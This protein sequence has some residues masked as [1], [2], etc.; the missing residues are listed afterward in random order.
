MQIQNP[1]TKIT[2]NEIRANYISQSGTEV[3]KM[4]LLKNE[5]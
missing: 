2:S 3:E 1:Q 4:R 5:T